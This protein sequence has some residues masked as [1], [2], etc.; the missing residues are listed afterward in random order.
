MNRNLQNFLD[1]QQFHSFEGER[2][3]ERLNE[4]INECGYKDSGFRNGSTVEEFLKD[5]PGA[6]ENLL[7]WI[8]DNHSDCFEDYK[9]QEYDNGE[10]FEE[11]PE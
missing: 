11:L 6:I 2:G 5:N 1:Q 4:V 3:I 7:E 9:S 10:T 8:G